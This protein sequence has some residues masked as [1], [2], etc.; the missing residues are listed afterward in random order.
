VRPT[1][2]FV[3]SGGKTPRGLYENLASSHRTSIDWSRVRFFWGD[4]R[5]VPPDHPESNF[6]LAHGTLLQPLGISEEQIFRFHTELSPPAHAALDYERQLRKLYGTPR[7]DFALQ[8]LGE[9]GHTASLFPDAWNDWS[10]S[11]RNGHWVAAPWVPHLKEFR[12]TLL[13][14]VLSLSRKVVF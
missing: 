2:D 6:K 8:G 11:E 7:F 10:E 14:R 12:L 1:F 4:E 5:C 9:D 13:P 3:L